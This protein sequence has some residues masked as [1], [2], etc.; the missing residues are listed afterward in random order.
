MLRE[1][2]AWRQ[3]FP[4]VRACNFG[5]KPLIVMTGARDAD[6]QWRATWVNGM[7]AELAG[8]STHG[9]QIVLEKSR[10]AIPFDAPDAV[11]DAIHAVYLIAKN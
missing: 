8:L 2:E 7:Q 9:K 11:A 6:P 3:S 1:G 10:H 5:D 4:Q